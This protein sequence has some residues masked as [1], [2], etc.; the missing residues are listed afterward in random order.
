M[1]AEVFS[2]PGCRTESIEPLYV[3]CPGHTVVDDTVYRTVLG[4]R[5]E[6]SYCR[7]AGLEPGDMLVGDQGYGPSI[8]KITTLGESMIL[9]RT[10]HNGAP[11]WSDEHAVTLS[12]RDWRLL[13]A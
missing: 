1:S 11:R 9:A 10:S 3:T 7:D 8:F 2:C 4:A 5:D 6:A 13:D 12:C